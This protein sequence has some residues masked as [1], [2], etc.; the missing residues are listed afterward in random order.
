MN[1]GF[2]F[3]PLKLN[4]GLAEC[5]TWN[6]ATILAR[7]HRLADQAVLIWKSPSLDEAIL[8]VYRTNKTLASAYSVESYPQLKGPVRELFDA[9]RQEVLALDDCVR[10]EFLKLYIAYKA[11][12]NFVDVVPQAS[13]LRLSLNMEF[14]KLDDPRG[15]AKDV[16][17]VGR[18]G[19][20]DVEIGLSKLEDIPY[21]IGLIRQALECQLGEDDSD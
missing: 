14:H 5:E 7:A 6:E 12:T 4:Q 8:D 10:E 18:W 9:L 13:R 20:G 2:R 3:S 17:E 21:V 11:E 16:S 19:N 1:G 15:L